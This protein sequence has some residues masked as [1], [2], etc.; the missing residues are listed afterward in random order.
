V[1]AVNTNLMNSSR[2][3]NSPGSVSTMAVMTTPRLST[4]NTPMITTW[5]AV[6]V[7]MPNTST[8]ATSIST[9]ERT[10]PVIT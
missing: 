2:A 8:R 1:E 7:N 9:D 10:G 3:S 6:R 4:V 5:R